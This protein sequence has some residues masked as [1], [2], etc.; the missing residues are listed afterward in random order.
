MRIR[1]LLPRLAGGLV[2]LV[3]I[4][5]ALIHPVLFPSQLEAPAYEVDPAEGKAW[6][7]SEIV[8]EVRGHLSEEEALKDLRIDP[9]LPL[10]EQEVVVEHEAGMGMPW[11]KVLPWAKTTVRI[12]PGR[13]QVLAPETNYTMALDDAEVSFSTITVPKVTSFE[14]TNLSPFNHDL[15]STT[16]EL[17]ITFNEQIKWDPGLFH[18]DPPAA[19][20]TSA[21]PTPEGGTLVRISKPDRWANGTL[22]KLHIDASVED[23]H[24]HS[25]GELFERDFTTIPQPRVLA[26]SPVGESVAQDG[27]VQIEF[28]RNVDRASVEAAFHVDPPVPGR[29]EWLRDGMMVWRPDN[30]QY[31]AWYTVSLTGLDPTGD[32][33]VPQQWSFRVHDPPVF[34]QI[35][36]KQWGPSILQGIATGGLGNYT[37]EW[38]TGHTVPRFLFNGAPGEQIVSLTVHSGDQS[39]T[40][41]IQFWGGSY[42]ASE[43]PEGWY[44]VDVSVC[45][46]AEDLPSGTRSHI[47]RVDLKDPNVEARAVPTGDRLGASRRVS[48][49]ARAR[50]SVA[51]INGDFFYSARGGTYA[52]GPMMSG[53]NFKSAPASRQSVL[54]VDPAG[55]SW[56]GMAPDVRVFLQSADGG[57]LPVQ[58]VNDIPGPNAASVFNAHWGPVLSI[59]ADGCAA[60]YV[61][62]D[63]KMRG[64]DTFSCG[65]LLNVGLP[66]GGYVVVARGAAADWLWERRGTPLAVQ[67]T[68]PL[69]T[70]EMMVGGSHVLLKDGAPVPVPADAYHPRSMLG[71]TADG[72]LYMVAVD[73]WGEDS[74]GMTL[75]QLQAYAAALG[76]KNAINLDG[77]GS[78]TMAV[79]GHLVNQPS[80]GSE[81]VVAGMVEVGPPHPRCVNAFVRCD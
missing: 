60:T 74:G 20:I 75:P 5:I 58:G 80:D 46:H 59:G 35:A 62:T 41:A 28:D 65:S 10:T 49:A 72:F 11:H 56:A 16:S 40:S 24:G 7:T 71:V 69:G 14:V 54:A 57:S 50:G 9:P 32:A 78:T 12:N 26:Y 30:L 76:L 63:T 13:A 38:N 43:C 48:E 19:V 18:I 51:A 81:R 66:V 77:G 53:G 61:P 79:A 15:A 44:M 55:A 45:Y 67:Y 34:V 33:I 39:A 70:A 42:Q 6:L 22:Y 52:L 29:F 17:L 68:L 23:V 2:V 64:P 37:Y 31:S 73:G 36:G 27:G 3:G 1:Y 47:T 8:L 25:G 21:E 4:Y